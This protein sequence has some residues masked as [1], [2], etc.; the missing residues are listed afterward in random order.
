MSTIQ[1]ELQ[2]IR[3]VSTWRTRA[4]RV[5]VVHGLA[6]SLLALMVPS[7]V[8][9][10]PPFFSQN[11]PT[12][13]AGD[14][15]RPP[16]EIG[17]S[18]GLALAGLPPVGGSLNFGPRVTVP[19]HRNTA[20]ETILEIS[21]MDTQEYIKGFWLAQVKHVLRPATTD[22][23][24]LFL[25]AGVSSRFFLA[26]YDATKWRPAETIRR[27]YGPGFQAGLGVQRPLR[28]RVAARADFQ[29]FGG[30]GH[31]EGTFGVRGSVGVSFA[32]G[33]YQ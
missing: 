5:L 12:L 7:T 22:R 29:V 2:K 1:P 21:G 8:E 4:V 15:V 26:H 32:L 10:Q 24:E 31:P 6:V 13:V 11:G 23:A 18:G 30:G 9:A 17:G 19:V 3:A 33:R 14:G 27:F 28:P 25:T 16:V 20:I